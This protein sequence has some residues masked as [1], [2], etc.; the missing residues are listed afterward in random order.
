MAGIIA[1]CVEQVEDVIATG[2]RWNSHA[3]VNFIFS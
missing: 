1:L 3:R 2:G